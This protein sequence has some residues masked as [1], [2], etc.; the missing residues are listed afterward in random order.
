MLLARKATNKQQI[1]PVQVWFLSYS[2]LRRGGGSSAFSSSAF[3]AIFLGFAMLGE[4]FAYVTV[5]FF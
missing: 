1:L 3:P 5:I 2:S 4:I